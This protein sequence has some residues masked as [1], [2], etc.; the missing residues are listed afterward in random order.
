MDQHGNVGLDPRD[1]FKFRALKAVN[2]KYGFNWGIGL[3]RQ[4]FNSRFLAGESIGFYR[5]VFHSVSAAHGVRYEWYR[6]SNFGEFNDDNS[7][8]W[9][10]G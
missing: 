3:A 1:F 8:Y 4:K 7:A 9:G 5:L 2:L 6:K 10:C